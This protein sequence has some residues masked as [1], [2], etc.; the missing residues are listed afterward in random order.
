[1]PKL[2]PNAD[3]Y[4]FLVVDKQY[5]ALTKKQLKSVATPIPDDD[6]SDISELLN[7]LVEE[8]FVLADIVGPGESQVRPDSC[9]CARSGIVQPTSRAP[10][11]SKRSIAGSHSYWPGVDLKLRIRNMI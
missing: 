2:P 11:R 4:L 1:M 6:G 7:S 8:G 5:F 9:A 10:F 3:G